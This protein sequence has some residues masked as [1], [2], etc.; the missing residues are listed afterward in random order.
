M[1]A[2]YKV[3]KVFTN[4]V[5]SYIIILILPCV[6]IGLMYR[7]ALTL[8]QQSSVDESLVVLRQAR[9]DLNERIS[10]MDKASMQLVSDKDVNAIM[11]LKK[12]EPGSTAVY[13]VSRFSSQLS[14]KLS[15]AMDNN[16]S[17]HLMFKDNELVFYG[18]SMST[19][20]PFY[21][22]TA[23]NYQG[24]DYEQWYNEAFSV[25]QRTLLP[26]RSIKTSSGQMNAITY[27]YPISK[28]VGQGNGGL[29]YFLLSDDSILKS[30][31]SANIDSIGAFFIFD[32]KGQPLIKSGQFADTALKID[33]MTRPEGYF[34]LDEDN[35]TDIVVYTK[36]DLYKLYFASRLPE[37]V[38]MAK[39]NDIQ[40]MA[41]TLFLLTLLLEV[42]LGLS[43]AR[44]NATPINNFVRNV[45][46]FFSGDSDNKTEISQ[47]EYLE[48]SLA[49][50]IDARKSMYEA[51]EE[52]RSLERRLFLDKL[53]QGGFPS[54]AEVFETAELAGVELRAKQYCVV[55]FS[56]CGQANS[57]QT[58]LEKESCSD[59]KGRVL[60]HNLDGEIVLAVLGFESEDTEENI[61]KV[62]QY[63]K[64]CLSLLKKELQAEGRAGV[65]RMY[66]DSSS[67]YFSHGQACY[68]LMMD[69]ESPD[70]PVI[71][72]MD[73]P[74]NKNSFHYPVEL[75]KK[76][77]NAAKHR[78]I[79]E[80][81]SAFE[82]IKE[83]NLTKRQL[84][85]RMGGILCANLEA[86]LLKISQD[87][88]YAAD[89]AEDTLERTAKLTELSDI[90]I[91]LEQV[92]LEIGSRDEETR[93]FR[94]VFLK[95]E[96]EAYLA[97]NY[98]NP[99]LGVTLMAQ[100]FN[101]SESYFS[102]VFKEV[103]NS[104]FSA[105]LE[106]LRLDKAK[107]LIETGNFDIE[108][109]AQMVGYNNSTTFRRAFKRVEG[110]APRSY[111][112]NTGKVE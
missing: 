90:L 92:F 86:S 16:T 84:S 31:S 77:V 23:L 87:V 29:I 106:T 14:G 27:I 60:Y 44:S 94:Q 22:R 45:R 34:Y 41:V 93:S 110:I 53:F 59:F 6:M 13:A 112:Q 107:A 100:Y 72:Y 85:K 8:A 36:S 19:G 68:C 101:L 109:I 20:L 38:V 66:D 108:Y 98:A 35:S 51:I 65:G 25:S 99:M 10:L 97:E 15:I 79:K 21:F 48:K 32:E 69:G 4:L 71:E 95:Q 74:R 43:F 76:L 49:T 75:E 57:V 18:N 2:R 78:N 28:G 33:Q 50:M 103:M 62:H 105:C 96:I 17:F 5:I 102:Q 88:T 61:L 11:S 37:S 67:I 26:S 7:Q 81:Q 40:R 83:E 3:K 104:S 24:M 63:A 73:I 111:K 9:A 52:K 47:Y 56:A 70:E 12:L 30:V 82:E 54:E 1:K 42:L 89:L 46:F 39:A 80:I 64:N 58:L 55:A 91:R